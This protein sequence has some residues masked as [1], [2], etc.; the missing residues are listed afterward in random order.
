MPLQ[1]PLPPTL[2]PYVSPPPRSSLTLVTSVLGATSNWLVLRFLLAALGSGST[3]AGTA[4]INGREDGGNGDEGLKGGRRKVVLLS[5][6]RNWEFWKS[7]AKRL[8]LDLAR[9][10]DQG[11]FAFIDGLSEL[12]YSSSASSAPSPPSPSL[13]HSGSAVPPSRTTTLPVRSPPGAVPARVPGTPPA[14]TGSSS[15]RVSTVSESTK[16]LRFTGRGTAALDSLEKDVLAVVEELKT[17]GPTAVNSDG[18]N[19]ENGIVLVI[20]QPDL[21]LAATGSSQGIGA[22]EMGEWIM[23]LEQ[24]VHSTILTV[25]AD[26]PLVHNAAVS[27]TSLEGIATPLE[28]EH[29][30]FVIGL[31]HRARMVMQLRNLDTGAAKDVS[32]VLRVSKGGGALDEELD[33]E[34]KEVLYFVQRDAGVRVFGR[35]E[36]S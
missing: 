35:G 26:F 16:R 25:S 10:S 24:R 27:P 30:A 21:L 13:A 8:G 17:K 36:M 20:D 31:A 6:L 15:N 34:E 18:S 22:T 9:L 14:T 19:D 32:G 4:T 7:E 28:T 12:F 1:P 29:A 5:F 3:R 11:R 33:W 23:G 2:I